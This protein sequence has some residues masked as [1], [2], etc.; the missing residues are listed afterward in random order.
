MSVSVSEDILS[1]ILL[2]LLSAQFLPRIRADHLNLAG[3]AGIGG[4]CARAS[5]R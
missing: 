3:I 1:N 5:S 4:T 2:A